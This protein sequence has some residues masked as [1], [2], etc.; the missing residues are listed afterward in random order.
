MFEVRFSSVAFKYFKKLKERELTEKYYRVILEIG[1]DPYAGEKK[2]G[3]LSGV[4]CKHFIYKKTKYEVA[5][6]I[7][8]ETEVV[9]IVLAGT[10]E[11]FYKQLKNCAKHDHL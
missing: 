5:Y 8:D 3:D 6:R 7:Y 1:D 10:R 2:T 4:Y 11:N 9:V